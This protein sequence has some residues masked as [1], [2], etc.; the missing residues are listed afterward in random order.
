LRCF[1]G[2]ISFVFVFEW[3]E[4]ESRIG[5]K[6]VKIG[7]VFRGEI[8]PCLVANPQAILEETTSHKHVLREGLAQT[9]QEKDCHD[10][11]HSVTTQYHR[12]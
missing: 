2:K 1:G 6:D 8:K 5:E 7:R 10:P 3:S 4:A 9:A 11:A 12:D